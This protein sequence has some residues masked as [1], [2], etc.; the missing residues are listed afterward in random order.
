MFLDKFIPIDIVEPFDPKVLYGSSTL[1]L[2]C[3]N[4]LP[5]Y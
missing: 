5:T 1:S 2:L 3:L 4:S